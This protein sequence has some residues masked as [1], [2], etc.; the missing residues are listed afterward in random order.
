[1]SN[2]QKEVKELVR[3]AKRQGWRVK[4]TTKGYLLFDPTGECMELLHMTPSNPRW[5]RHSLSQMRQ[6]GFKWKGR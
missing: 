4:R 2:A 1:M 6:Y 3:A 5:R